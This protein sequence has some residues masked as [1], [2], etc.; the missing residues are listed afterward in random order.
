[1]VVSGA[2][3]THIFQKLK[4]GMLGD[5]CHTGYGIDAGPFDECRDH[6]DAPL[7][8]QTVHFCVFPN[9]QIIYK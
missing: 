8:A 1:M 2:G 9:D 6:L 5:T 4:N 3:T 7:D